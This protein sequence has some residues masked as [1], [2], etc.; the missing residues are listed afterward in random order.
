VADNLGLCLL[1]EGEPEAALFWL[2]GVLAQDPADARAHLV[3][4]WALRRIG[5]AEE[6]DRAWKTASELASGLAPLQKEDV[7]RRLERILRAERPLLASAARPDPERVAEIVAGAERLLA[8]GDRPQALAE[9]NRALHLDPSAP[10]AHLALAH[11]H[12]AAGD[13]ERA[14]QELRMALWSRED[15]EVR[16]ELVALL[17]ELGRKAD[18]RAEAARAPAAP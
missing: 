9:L 2:R 11:L 8:A 7:G 5:R 10:R 18:A 13:R 12:R 6:A 14:V 4:S 1:A 17:E 16:A 3:S 15:A